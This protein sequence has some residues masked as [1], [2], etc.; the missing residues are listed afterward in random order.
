MQNEDLFAVNTQ[1]DPNNVI[2]QSCDLSHME[3]NVL[4]TVLRSK[5]WNMIRL[6]K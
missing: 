5:S 2:P 6:A 3:G 1:A 4:H